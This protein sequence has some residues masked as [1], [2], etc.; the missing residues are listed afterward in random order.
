MNRQ[1]GWDEP[2]YTVVS[3]PRHLPLHPEPPNYDFRTRTIEQIH[4][5]E[6]NHIIRRLTVRECL[7]LQT[8]PD[9]YYFPDIPGR[10][11]NGVLEK[12]HER[13]SGIPPVI[14]HMLGKQLAD[15]LTD[16]IYDKRTFQK[17]L[18]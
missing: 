6:K 12:Q 15:I 4:E 2:S 9:W 14:S 5:D 18:F 7:R 8:V 1:R 11:L 16:Q 13:C 17:R 3:N 10:K